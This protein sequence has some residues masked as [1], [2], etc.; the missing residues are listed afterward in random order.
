MQSKDEQ[1]LTWLQ[2]QRL[3]RD[4]ITWTKSNSHKPIN[5]VT[6]YRATI[7]RPAG[8]QDSELTKRQQL[9]LRLAQQF[10]TEK[11]QSGIVQSKQ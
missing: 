11:N 1:I 2:E 3:I 6:Y 10:Y 5:R 4:F 8:V 7:Y 9:A